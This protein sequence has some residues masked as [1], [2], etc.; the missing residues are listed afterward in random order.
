MASVQGE[1]RER[2]CL[3]RRGCLLTT[4]GVTGQGKAERGWRGGYSRSLVARSL[5]VLCSFLACSLLVLVNLAV[6]PYSAEIAEIAGYVRTCT[7]LAGRA[8]KIC[9]DMFG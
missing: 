4:T 2:S 3:P 9:L 5:L 7:H 6:S 8:A 1:Q